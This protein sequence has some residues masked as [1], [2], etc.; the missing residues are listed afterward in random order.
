MAKLP[1][2]VTAL[3]EVDGRD[4]KSVEHIGRTIREAGYI[5]TG[6]RGSG[7]AEMSP[8][9]AAN[10]IIALNGADTP[11][12]GPIAIDRFRSLKQWFQGTSADFKAQ[13][14]S[15]DGAPE[16]VQN[17]ADCKVFGDALEALIEGVPGLAASFHHFGVE[18]FP[19]KDGGSY[20]DT[21][22]LGSLRL[23]TFG[24]DVTFERYATKI[25]LFAMFG[26]ERRVQCEIWFMA[27][28]DR[29]ESGFYGNSWPD[30]KVTSTIG[31]PTLVA[32]WQGLNPGVDLPGIPAAPVATEADEE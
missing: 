16:A 31:M 5:P 6:K 23:G 32:A 19:G 28:P 4:R 3:A 15:F 24:L 10:F 2:L 27:D 30:R 7:A 8:R 22:L 13:V 29:M 1:A 17:A 12:D 21:R 14:G 20:W 9:E 18:N 11:K 26:D 25:E